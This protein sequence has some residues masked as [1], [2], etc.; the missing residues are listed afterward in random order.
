MGNKKVC[1][2][3]GGVAMWAGDLGALSLYFALKVA[4]GFT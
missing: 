2:E 1:L 4:L 3:T